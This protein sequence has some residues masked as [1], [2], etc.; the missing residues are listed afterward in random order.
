MSAWLASLSLGGL[1]V[2]L[3][4]GFRLIGSQLATLLLLVT[5]LIWIMAV[6]RLTPALDLPQ[7]VKRGFGRSSRLRIAARWLQLAWVAHALPGAAAAWT[8][9]GPMP[10]GL[11]IVGAVT[12]VAG[13]A[14][15]LCLAVLLGRL[16]DWAR[17]GFAEKAFTTCIMSAALA[18]PVLT[19]IPVMALL[20]GPLVLAFLAVALAIMVISLLSF[21]VGL[22]ALA[23]TVDWSLAHARDRVD[24]SRELADRVVPRDPSAVPTPAGDDPIPL[25]GGD[26][27]D[28]P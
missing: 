17:D 24:R 4:G 18:I 26:D 25:A 19:I 23:R 8:G 21:P 14:G 22:F 3:M 10:V 20:A 6:W 7:A 16:A 5:T 28:A 13:M 27:E 15:V 9:G 2:L 1:I 12:W 11:M